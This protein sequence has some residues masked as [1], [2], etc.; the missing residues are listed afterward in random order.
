MIS[1]STESDATSDAA[2]SH[3]QSEEN[4]AN[5]TAETA[6]G[7]YPMKEFSAG[8]TEVV[9]SADGSRESHRSPGP[10]LE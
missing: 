10:T 1:V 7:G 2:Q 6:A 8:R 3:R 9:N 4:P 5:N